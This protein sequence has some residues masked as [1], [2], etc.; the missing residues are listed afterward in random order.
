[1]AAPGSGRSTTS[2]SIRSSIIPGLLIRI[3]GEEL[4]GRTEL[5]VEPQARRVEG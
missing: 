4:A 1:M 2:E 3:C 5:D